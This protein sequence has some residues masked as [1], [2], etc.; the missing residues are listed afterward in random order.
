MGSLKHAVLR[1]GTLSF[2]VGVIAA[3]GRIGLYA[4]FGVIGFVLTLIAVL[5]LA[6]T[7]GAP[8]RRKDAQTVLAILL[9]RNQ[10]DAPDAPGTPPAGRLGRGQADGSGQGSAGLQPWLPVLASAR[11]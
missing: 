11:A 1:L 2:P 7:F 5:A 8:D 3:Y 6:G 9:G 10:P 4:A